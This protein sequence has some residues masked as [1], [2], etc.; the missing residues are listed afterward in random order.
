MVATGK[1]GRFQRQG[2][3][4]SSLALAFNMQQL[5]PLVFLRCTIGRVDLFAHIFRRFLRRLHQHA[6]GHSAIVDAVDEDKAARIAIRG[7]G[8]K[9]NIAV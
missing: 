1:Q 8:V 5:R 9:S 7:V 4:H 2:L 3:L 6:S